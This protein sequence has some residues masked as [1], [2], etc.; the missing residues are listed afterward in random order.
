M[1]KNKFILIDGNN[2]AHI[3]FHRGK[4][5]ILKNK[6]EDS[7]NKKKNVE[8]TQEDFPAVEGMMYIV[9]FRKLHKYFKMFKGYYFVMAWDNPGSSEW[10]RELYPEYKASRDYETDPIWSILFNVINKL[11]EV[12][13]YY[14][15]YQLKVEKLEADDILYVLSRT[16]K[17]QKVVILSGDSD[18]IQAAQE[19]GVKIYHPIKDKYVEIPKTYDHCMYKAIKGDTSDEIDG[20]YGYGEVKATRLAEEIYNEDFL[21]NINTNKLDKEQQDAVLRNLKLIRISNNPNLKNLKV[22]VDEILSHSNVD[23]HKIQKFYFEH[24]LKS[25][26]ETFDGVVSI[27]N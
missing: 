3:A 21:D 6:K 7:K 15:I 8:L 23:L 20:I 27:F 18:M 24:K 2:L 25:L 5:I 10:R 11:R 1:D 4:S 26:I 17:D 9:F 16:L 14:P 22:N 13:E 19:F 12:L